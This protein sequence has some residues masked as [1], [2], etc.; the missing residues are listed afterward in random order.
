MQFNFDELLK[1]G[2]PSIKQSR[3]LN[4]I[5]RNK[6]SEAAKIRYKIRQSKDKMKSAK[7]DKLKSEKL[8]YYKLNNDLKKTNRDWQKVKNVKEGK[9]VFKNFNGELKI[10]KSYLKRIKNPNEYV[11][12]MHVRQV[13]KQAEKLKENG[14]TDQA[15]GILKKVNAIYS[16]DSKTLAY[17]KKQMSKAGFKPMKEKEIEKQKDIFDEL[18]EDLSK[19]KQDESGE[20]VIYENYTVDG[21]EIMVIY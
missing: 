4:K 1:G 16:N 3:E 13:V 15:K 2:E 12:R 6:K 9:V 19:K 5:I 21:V 14:K 11:K 17:Q 7:G 20:T 8:N 10:K 18:A